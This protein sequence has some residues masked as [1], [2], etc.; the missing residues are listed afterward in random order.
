MDANK[1]CKDCQNLDRCLNPMHF[2]VPLFC[3]QHDYKLWRKKEA[4]ID[5]LECCRPFCRPSQ[6]CL[7][8]TAPKTRPVLCVRLACRDFDAVESGEIEAIWLEAKKLSDS[9]R[10][11]LESAPKNVIF[12][13]GEIADR[14]LCRILSISR[15][16]PIVGLG[17]FYCIVIRLVNPR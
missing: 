13:R 10:R 1:Q 4:K 11:A 15:F 6:I 12:L 17:D 2:S 8:K 16:T 9:E 7:D 14:L 3:L 5:V